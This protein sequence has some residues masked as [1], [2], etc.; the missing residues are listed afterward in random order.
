MWNYRFSERKCREKMSNAS[1]YMKGGG[2]FV[3]SNCIKA[4]IGLNGEC[5]RGRLLCTGAVAI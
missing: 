5:I 4:V 2:E 3:P 1:F